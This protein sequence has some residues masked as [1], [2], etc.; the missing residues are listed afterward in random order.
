MRVGAGEGHGVL[1]AAGGEAVVGKAAAGIVTVVGKAGVGKAVVVVEGLGA[2]ERSGCGAKA[3]SLLV[4]VLECALRLL[5]LGEVLAHHVLVGKVLLA[6]EALSHTVLPH[7]V[8]VLLSPEAG[9][10]STVLS[11][12]DRGSTVHRKVRSGA[13]L[14]HPILILPSKDRSSG[15]YWKGRRSRVLAREWLHGGIILVWTLEDRVLT[16]NELRRHLSCRSLLLGWPIVRFQLRDLE[17]QLVHAAVQSTHILDAKRVVSK[18]D[19]LQMI[20][21]VFQRVGDDLLLVTV[22]VILREYRVSPRLRGSRSV[23]VTGKVH[24]LRAS[25]AVKLDRLGVQARRL[26]TLGRSLEGHHTAHARV[27]RRV[28]HGRLLVC[29][30]LLVPVG[31]LD[32]DGLRAV[33][34]RRRL[35]DLLDKRLEAG[36]VL[37]HLQSLL[38][39]CHPQS[40]LLVDRLQSILK[41]LF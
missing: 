37:C 4:G 13:V 24:G 41:L 8:L 17:L 29:R 34:V 11:G 27:R 39:L 16:T 7:A 18:S 6:H 28:L 36:L 38:L 21:G 3:V 26:G 15:A 30:L 35:V 14:A 23:R 2:V 33:A 31:R 22:V 1:R 40:I 10:S 5:R 19:V 9:S 25:A 32:V 12:K 20:R